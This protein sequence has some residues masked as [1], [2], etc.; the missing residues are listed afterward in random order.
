MCFVSN[1]LEAWDIIKCRK[2]QQRKRDL[3]KQCLIQC[4]TT[5]TMKAIS[6]YILGYFQER[7][8]REKKE[9]K[10][11]KNKSIWTTKNDYENKSS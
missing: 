9:N 11:K 4:N 10:Q 8:V 7:T 2:M 3:S 1:F 5:V 6:E